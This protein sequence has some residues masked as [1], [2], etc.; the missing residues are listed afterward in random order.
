MREPAFWGA[1]SRGEPAEPVQMDGE[2]KLEQREFLGHTGCALQRGE[3][4]CEVSRSAQRRDRLV[5]ILRA[6]ETEL[7][8]GTHAKQPGSL[9]SFL[10]PPSDP[11]TVTVRDKR[12]VSL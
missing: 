4:R 3:R 5:L 2:A 8:R 10:Q 9:L 11:F 1:A 12:R 6:G 7:G